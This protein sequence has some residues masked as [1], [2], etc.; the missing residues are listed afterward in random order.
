MTGVRT[1]G[2]LSVHH[3][4]LEDEEDEERKEER[5]GEGEV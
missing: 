3:G 5:E 1:A 4:G 2:R